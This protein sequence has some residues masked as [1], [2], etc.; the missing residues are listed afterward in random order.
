M[1]IAVLLSLVLLQACSAKSDAPVPAGA[2]PVPMAAA[3]RAVMSPPA[4]KAAALQQA[5]SG[6]AVVRRHLAVRHDLQ[7]LTAADA[8]ETAWKAAGEACTAAGCEV[9]NAS[10]SRDE[11]RRPASAMLEARVPPAALPAFLARVSALGTVGQHSTSSE[12]KTD[13]V[14][15]TEARQKNMAEFRDNLRTLMA[16]PNAKLKDL[17]EV[18]RELTRVQSELDSLATRRKLLAQQTEQVHVTLRFSALPSVLGGG[19]W[20][21]VTQAVQRAG[22]VLAGSL[23]VM[24]ELFV[25]LLPWAAAGGGVFLGLRA[26]WRRKRRAAAR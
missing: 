13:E 18:E 15:D 3:P 17:I 16:T 1:K 14:V 22:H 7:L 10:I 4:A 9:L 12:D 19:A 11:D 20:S 8:V 5:T 21:P 23:A 6:D 26:L 2:P 25:A 24:I